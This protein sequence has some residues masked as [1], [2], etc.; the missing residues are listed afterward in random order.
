M[1]WRRL[2]ADADYEEGYADAMHHAAEVLAAIPCL[3]PDL[4][5]SPLRRMYW[6]GFQVAK[7]QAVAAVRRAGGLDA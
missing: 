1:R 7:E 6:S 3:E 2:K 5:D 4:L